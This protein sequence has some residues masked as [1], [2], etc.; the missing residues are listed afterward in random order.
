MRHGETIADM[1]AEA[2]G[3]TCE[4][5]QEMLEG[6]ARRRLLRRIANRFLPLGEAA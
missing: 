5:C 4:S 6:L 3:L 2:T 1:V